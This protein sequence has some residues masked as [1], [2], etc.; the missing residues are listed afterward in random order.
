MCCRTFCLLCAGH[1]R[2]SPFSSN[3]YAVDFVYFTCFESTRGLL[4]GTDNR[5]LTEPKQLQGT[6]INLQNNYV[7]IYTSFRL[8]RGWELSLIIFTYLVPVY[9]KYINYFNLCSTEYGV[10]H[11]LKGS[12]YPYW[13][14]SGICFCSQLLCVSLVH[15]SVVKEKYDTGYV[16]DSYCNHSCYICA[17]HSI[18]PLALCSLLAS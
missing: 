16:P 13:S 14:C 9:K 11:L 6:I 5:L 10:C 15:L 8:P 3:R 12:M 1:T 4:S 2:L 17:I 18:M 7:H